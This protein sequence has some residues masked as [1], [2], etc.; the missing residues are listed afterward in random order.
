MLAAATPACSP[1]LDLL[2]IKVASR[3]FNVAIKHRNMRFKLLVFSMTDI[4]NLTGDFYMM[5]YLQLAKNMH[6]SMQNF[7]HLSLHYLF[8]SL[9]KM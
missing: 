5:I 4:H 1:A 3:Y 7:E 8:L 2:L 6:S 9:Y